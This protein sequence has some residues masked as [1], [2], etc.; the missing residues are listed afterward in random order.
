MSGNTTHTAVAMGTDWAS[1]A[2]IGGTIVVFVAGVL[3]G[4]L[5]G[6]LCGRFGRPA[7]LAAEAA[8]LWAG[9]ASSLG[10][11]G[12]PWTTSVLGFAMGLQNA[13][14]HH[15]NGISVSLTYVTGTLV[16]IGRGLAE[17][18]R[19]MKPVSGVLPYLGLWLAVFVGSVLGAAVARASAV[20]AIAIAAA[21]ASALA[22]LSGATARRYAPAR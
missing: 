19:G 8:S 12:E 22:I 10:G 3:V 11:F 20:D 1:F 15:A 4:E 14:V 7:V 17:A 21:A 2:R 18:L 6:P 13:S 5:L 9:L 16:K